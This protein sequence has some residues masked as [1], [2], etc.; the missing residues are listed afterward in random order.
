MYNLKQIVKSEDAP[1]LEVFPIE[2]QS[3]QCLFCMG[4]E[5]LPYFQ[6][7]FRWSRP[8]KMRYHVENVHIKFIRPYVRVSCPHPTCKT[9][10]VVLEHLEHFKNHAQRV[11]KIKLRP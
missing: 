6:R 7:I 10:G 8:T 9:E 2:C 3:S 11:H 1:E 4:N 5:A